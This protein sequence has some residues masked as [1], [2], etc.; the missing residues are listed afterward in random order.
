MRRLFAVAI[1]GGALFA[2]VGC[3]SSESSSPAT[4][5]E[6]QACTELSNLVCDKIAA[7]SPT[8]LSQGWGDVAT[9]KSRSKLECM[10]GFSAPSTSATPADTSACVKAAASITCEQLIDNQ[11]P[12]SC[13]P[14]PG[15]I[16]D[17]KACG[18]DAQCKSGFCGFDDDKKICGVCGPKPAEGGACVDDD[19]PSGLKCHL[20]KCA[21]PAAVGATCDDAVLCGAG[22]T[23]VSGTCTKGVATEGA[24]CDPA[25]K[26]KPAC[27]SLAGFVCL[28]P[29]GPGSGGKC[30]KVA[31][32]AIG[33]ECGLDIDMAA[34]P[35]V[36]KSLT[37]CEKAGWCEGLD[38][39]KG[40]FK[41][42]CKA[43]AADGAACVA[44]AG[45]EKGPGCLEPAECVDGVCKLPD[46]AACK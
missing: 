28:E 16:D 6:E 19:C 18:A 25:G 40:K 21:K 12:D 2:L 46:A 39:A 3:S 8:F 22:T 1:V 27:D 14:K 45:F 7:C 33:G 42:T 35:P 26:T 11:L 43:A 4:V 32:A 15:G 41:G 37:G 5:T 24:E 10:Q 38:T 13:K 31:V 23:C 29:S 30:Y 44:D 34:S 20:G 9:C 36:I 17:G